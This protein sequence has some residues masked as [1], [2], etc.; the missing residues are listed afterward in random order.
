MALMQDLRPLLEGDIA[1]SI[2]REFASVPGSYV[3]AVIHPRK[4]EA[5]RAKG[6][7]GYALSEAPSLPGCSLRRHTLRRLLDLDYPCLSGCI[8]HEEILG[9]DRALQP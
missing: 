3:A 1:S 9:L 8:V 4:L 7:Q 2:W 6:G 5:S